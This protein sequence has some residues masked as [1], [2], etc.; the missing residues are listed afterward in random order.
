MIRALVVLL[1]A[2]AAHAE[3]IKLPN[4]RTTIDLPAA[5]KP[6]E[7]EALVLGAKGPSAELLAVTRASVPNPDAWRSK[8]REAYADHIEKGLAARI[9]GYKRTSRKLAAINSVPTLDLE[10]KRDDGARILVRVML[11]RTYALSLAIEVPKRAALDGARAIVTSFAA[12]S[13]TTSATSP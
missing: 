7:N 12:P 5:W 13:S 3:V 6:V 8:T 4:T 9:K 2:S 1:A 11:Y 10:A